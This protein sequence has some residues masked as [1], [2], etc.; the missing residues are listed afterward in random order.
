MAFALL[1]LPLNLR[2]GNNH[3]RFLRKL[4]ALALA[5]RE[6]ETAGVGD[7]EVRRERV[8]EGGI[9]LLPLKLT[10]FGGASPR[11]SVS[12]NR[13]GSGTII[14]GGS[15]SGKSSNDSGCGCGT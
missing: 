12:D 15:V 11:R 10:N 13:S 4:T 6:R 3:L 1:L 2:S 5:P 8:R 14:S 9:L 7:R